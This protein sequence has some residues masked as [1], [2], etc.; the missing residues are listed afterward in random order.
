MGRE[1][2][3]NASGSYDPSSRAGTHVLNQNS[4]EWSSLWW[5]LEP[6]GNGYVRIRSQWEDGTGYLGRIGTWNGFEW[7]PE[8]D[9]YV[10]ELDPDGW[11]QQ[12]MI[13]PD[14]AGGYNLVNRWHPES[15]ALTRD[16]FRTESGRFLPTNEITL[17]PLAGFWASQRWSLE[18]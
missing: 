5:A 18:G 2:D 15:G 1:G 11:H 3:L 8:Q 4:S 9:M 13:E 16:V 17:Y 14:P 12:W 10:G 7:V 6:V